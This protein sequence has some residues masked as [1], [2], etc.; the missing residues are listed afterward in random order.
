MPDFGTWPI[1]ASALLFLASGVVVWFAGSHLAGYVDA[2]AEHIGMG[3][4]IA[5][6]VILGGITSLPEVAVSVSSAIGGEPVMAVS[7][8]LGSIAMQVIVLAVADV[9]L[10][11]DALTSVLNS[12]IVPLQGT[13]GILL[14]AVVAIAISVSEV[15]V[16]PVGLWSIVIVAGYLESVALLANY[17]KKPPSWTARR[18]S[19]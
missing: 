13:F 7:T 19:G 18:T 8:L 1:R 5:G 15:A 17:E 16:G 10:G 11:R 3:Q 12:P 6:L 2:L 4:G 14:L 9:I